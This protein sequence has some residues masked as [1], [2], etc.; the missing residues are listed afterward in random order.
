MLPAGRMPRKEQPALSL[1]TSPGQ[2]ISLM[3]SSTTT[4]MRNLLALISVLLLAATSW[5]YGCGR[6]FQFQFCLHH[7]D[8]S[9]GAEVIRALIAPR[10]IEIATQLDARLL[11]H[12]QYREHLVQPG[13]GSL[14]VLCIPPE[15]LL[16]LF[17]VYPLMWSLDC[18]QRRAWRGW[19]GKRRGFPVVGDGP[20][21]KP[22]EPPGFVP[23][24]T[25]VV[26]HSEKRD[27]PVH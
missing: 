18:L 13:V 14:H 19:Q 12:R 4:D 11:L 22:E 1:L 6:L 27:A 8:G 25:A 3:L 10:E 5:L 2:H 9:E 20:S 17:A 7:A 23:D 26:I 16:L 15:C 24:S 21:S